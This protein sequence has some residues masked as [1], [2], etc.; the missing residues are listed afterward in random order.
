MTIDWSD[1]A[2]CNRLT[3]FVDPTLNRARNR[4]RRGVSSNVNLQAFIFLS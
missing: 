4:Q 1:P 3:E 2:A